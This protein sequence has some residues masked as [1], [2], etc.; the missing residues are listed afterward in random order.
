MRR[1]VPLE[2]SGK[3]RGRY[4]GSKGLGCSRS[5]FGKGN[6]MKASINL[7]R[8]DEMEFFRILGRSVTG[9]HNGRD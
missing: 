7:D 8:F 2:K 9:S 4:P 6:R 5:V 1:V 3:G